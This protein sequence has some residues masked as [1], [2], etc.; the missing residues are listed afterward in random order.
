[1]NP[2]RAFRSSLIATGA[3]C[4]LLAGCDVSHD[5][6]GHGDNVQ[7]RTP[8]GDMHIKTSND[9]NLAGIGL[10]PTRRHSRER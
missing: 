3:V 10:T 7:M 4:L 6:N 8:F 2:I 5:K 9:A 1:M